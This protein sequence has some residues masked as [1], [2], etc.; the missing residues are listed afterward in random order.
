MTEGDRRRGRAA[1]DV[2][3]SA[4]RWSNFLFAAPDPAEKSIFLFDIID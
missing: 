1:S 4:R 2:A 3:L